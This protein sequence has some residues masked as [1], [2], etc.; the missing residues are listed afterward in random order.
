MYDDVGMD[1]LTLVLIAVLAVGLAMVLGG[2]RLRAQ[3]RTDLRLAAIERKLD[4][5]MAHLEITEAPVDQ[6]DVLEHLRA[7][8]KIHAVKAYRDSTGASLA[9]A[10]AAVERLAREQ[11]LE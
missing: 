6:P 8:R 1:G 2:A 9:E 11:H 3:T 10:K 7:G 5:I 4:A